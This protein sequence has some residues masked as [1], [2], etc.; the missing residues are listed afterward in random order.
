MRFWC[1]SDS[2]LLLLWCDS[3][4][5][6]VYESVQMRIRYDF[7]TIL[8]RFRFDYVTK[9][10]DSNSNAILMRFEPI[11]LLLWCNSGASPMRFLYDS[12]VTMM[13]FWFNPIQV[14]F[15]CNLIFLILTRV[16]YPILLIFTSSQSQLYYC[17]TV[18][19]KYHNK[20]WMYAGK[21]LKSIQ[22]ALAAVKDISKP[23]RTCGEF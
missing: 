1:N 10:C 21:D 9:G 8:T 23:S 5:I 22:I 16:W 12:S 19:R 3:E 4:T 15:L 20:Q 7:E 6:L 2:T 17:R 11:L 18:N 13:R 14:R